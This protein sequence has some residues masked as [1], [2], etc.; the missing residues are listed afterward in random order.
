MVDYFKNLLDDQSLSVITD[1]AMS[2]CNRSMDLIS[3]LDENQQPNIN[4]LTH[5]EYNIS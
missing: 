5:Q 1:K 3:E 4:S 2:F